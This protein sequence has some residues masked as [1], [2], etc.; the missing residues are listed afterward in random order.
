MPDTRNNGMAKAS[1]RAKNKNN[2][3]NYDRLYPFIKKG[4]K[5]EIE[6]AA[7][8]AKESL[9][10]YIIKAIY[11]RMENEGWSHMAP[12][13]EDEESEQVKD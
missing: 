11:Q 9:N 10:I 4:G 3:K 13:G 2:S 12:P 8:A 1:T 7:A 5:K 6:E